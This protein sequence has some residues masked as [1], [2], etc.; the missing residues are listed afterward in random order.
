M[1]IWPTTGR[2]TDLNSFDNAK[3]AWP[4]MAKVYNPRNLNRKLLSDVLAKNSNEYAT[5][6]YAFIFSQ[7][8]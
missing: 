7:L 8:P 3:H 2:K 1:K 5:N 4:F 6:S